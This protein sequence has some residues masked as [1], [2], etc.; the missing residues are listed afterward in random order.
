MVQPLLA[1]K[2][3]GGHQITCGRQTGGMHPPGMLTRLLHNFVLHYKSI[4]SRPNSQMPRLWGVHHA[5]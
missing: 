4:R 2:P 1:L 3:S 5:S